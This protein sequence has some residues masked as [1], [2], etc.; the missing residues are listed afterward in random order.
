[1]CFRPEM[2]RA[3]LQPGSEEMLHFSR[4]SFH[5]ASDV[6]DVTQFQYNPAVLGLSCPTIT[7]IYLYGSLTAGGLSLK[8]ALISGSCGRQK[9]MVAYN[10]F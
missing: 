3:A 4:C 9:E 7:S 2:M 10:H 1:M 5:Q 6:R 8:C